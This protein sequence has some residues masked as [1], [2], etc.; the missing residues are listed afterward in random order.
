MLL[1]GILCTL[2][3]VMTIVSVLV[4]PFLTWWWLLPL[5]LV[6]YLGF[7]ILEL[8]ALWLL[9]CATRH[10][11]P[12]PA[13]RF[14]YRV[15]SRTAA[16][17]S[18]LCGVTIQ[19]SRSENLP[20]DK[21]FL[22]VSNHLSNLDPLVTMGAL[23]G[24]E[25]PFISKPENFKIPVA[26]PIMRVAGF[27]P[28]DRENP[29]NAVATIKKA[30]ATIAE[31]QLCMGIYPEGTRNKN[32]EGLLPFHNGSLKI[33]TNAKCPIVVV[34]LR[35]EPATFPYRRRA[36][37]RVVGTL[38]AATVQANRTDALTEQVRTLIAQDLGIE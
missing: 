37:V 16:W 35:Y 3:A 17:I 8:T 32:G 31:R 1:H 25:L 12:T 29:R 30:S 34:T 7:A 4:C 11:G 24:W 26:G 21:A 22:L 20:T 38:D 33:A 28:I 13:R 5:L 27:L 23:Y 36:H 18:L 19:V 2:T 6:Y 14:L 9:A 10:A 15:I